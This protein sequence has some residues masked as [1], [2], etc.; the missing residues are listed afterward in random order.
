M[1]CPQMCILLVFICKL[2][3]EKVSGE[4]WFIILHSNLWSRFFTYQHGTLPLQPQLMQRQC[5]SAT[6][7]AH[8]CHWSTVVIHNDIHHEKKKKIWRKLSEFRWKGIFSFFLSLCAFT[9]QLKGTCMTSPFSMVL[10]MCL[11]CHGN[12]FAI[13][14]EWQIFP[15]CMEKIHFTHHRQYSQDTL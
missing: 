1:E 7:E 4:I 8:A 5:G 15:Y 3:A 12:S 11:S 13:W 14:L 6:V 2:L 10:S 9:W